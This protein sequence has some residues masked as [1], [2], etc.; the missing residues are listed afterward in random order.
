MIDIEVAAHHL[1]EQPVAAP[2]PVAVIRTRASR[3]RVVR[4]M[5]A[6]TTVIVAVSAFGVA[7]RSSARPPRTAVTSAS[8]VPSKAPYVEPPQTLIVRDANQSVS[9]VDVSSGR[10]VSTIP[11]ELPF[12]SVSTAGTS[13]LSVSA[14]R[15]ASAG[16]APPAPLPDG[17]GRLGS[18]VEKIEVVNLDDIKANRVLI[19]GSAPELSG[20]GSLLL[21]RNGGASS[22]GNVHLADATTG[23][24]RPLPALEDSK[25][26]RVVLSVAWAKRS[27]TLL[28][29]TAARG[30]GCTG[31]P[32]ALPC[33]VPPQ[34]ISTQ[35]WAINVDTPRAAWHSVSTTGTW[36]SLRLLGA[37][38]MD[39]SVS[40]IRYS[41]GEV[42]A[43]NL[44]RPVEI[45]TVNADG[46]FV[47]H[48]TLTSQTSNI[49]TVDRSGTN[50]L[51]NTPTG[52]ARLSLNH[53][54]P[55]AITSLHAPAV[56]W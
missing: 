45:V 51:A 30:P 11:T 13:P 25:I 37:G 19:E 27:H 2:T 41:S 18:S 8:H 26:G 31:D 55:I 38:W 9:V 6:A 54:E 50:F 42:G 44:G 46:S 14:G 5:T 21:Y 47:D 23:A 15:V 24:G 48:V 4:N 53:P 40:A 20:D 49:L 36:G 10:I 52:I 34:P 35:G 16:S 22:Y 1:N 39:G 3:R 17:S 29:V 43:T 33:P 7:V 32:A 12:Q 56:A 28:A